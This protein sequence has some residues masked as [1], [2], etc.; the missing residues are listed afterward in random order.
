MPSYS[1]TSLRSLLFICVLLSGARVSFAEEPEPSLRQPSW[2]E[3]EQTSRNGFVS[4]RPRADKVAAGTPIAIDVT[5]TSNRFTT[6]RNPFWEKTATLPGNVAVFD[7][8][9]RFVGYLVDSSLERSLEQPE[10]TML[11]G[12]TGGTMLIVQTGKSTS[13]VA[14][15]KFKLIETLGP[16]QYSVQ[17][18]YTDQFLRKDG[19]GKV[20][21][22][23][24][25]VHFEVLPPSESQV[26][27]FPFLAP[28][29]L[30]Y[31]EVFL[32]P[33]I[34]FRINKRDRF[35][36]RYT[37]TT[38]ASIAVFNAFGYQ[39]L[40]PKGSQLFI[41]ADP[42]EPLENIN[43]PVDVMWA[44]ERFFLTLPPNAIAGSQANNQ[45]IGLGELKQ[46]SRSYLRPAGNYY[47]RAVYGDYFFAKSPFAADSDLSLQEWADKYQDRPVLVSEP[48]QVSYPGD[49]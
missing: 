45:V 22:V 38:D 46:R 21:A 3:I 7:N 35:E 16:G 43:R 37:N 5:F 44:D 23:S 40:K 41:S 33:K 10:V 25:V 49:F 8:H 47:L 30:G 34:E 18:Y 32:I 27:G 13:L 19:V 17:A 14:G 48:L 1:W 6:F 31:A 42:D 4:V 12:N 26:E 9:Q 29:P 11:S 2:L 36:M 24:E 39:M 28:S 15:T 20:T